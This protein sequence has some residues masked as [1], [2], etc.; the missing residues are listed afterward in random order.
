[1]FVIKCSPVLFR[2]SY[3]Y[4]LISELVMFVSFISELVMFVSFISELVMFVS[5]ISALVIMDA[6]FAELVTD[7]FSDASSDGED[8]NDDE[9]DCFGITTTT[10]EGE[11]SG[12]ED[13]GYVDL[14]RHF[15]ADDDFMAGW[16]EGSRPKQTLPFM[17]NTGL[18]SHVDLPDDPK[19]IDFLNLF[20]DDGHFETMAE[21]T[22]RYLET[23]ELRPHSRFHNWK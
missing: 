7:L 22:N 17:A 18:Q 4:F 16:V 3:V 10:T 15:R 21:E 23:N 19:P 12:F 2:A 20:L 13:V 5:F 8:S 1:M 6:E 11:F 14:D 9:P